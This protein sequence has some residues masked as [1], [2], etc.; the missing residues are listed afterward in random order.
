MFFNELNQYTSPNQCREYFEVEDYKNALVPCTERA[1]KGDHIAELYLARLYLDGLSVEIDYAKMQDPKQA[2]VFII[3]MNEMKV[4]IAA[5][6]AIQK[7]L[8]VFVIEKL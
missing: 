6:E 1:K 2:Q 4:E 3:K 7:K 8:S 5:R